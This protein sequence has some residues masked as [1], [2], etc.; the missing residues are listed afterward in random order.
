MTYGPHTLWALRTRCPRE[1]LTASKFEGLWSRFLPVQQASPRTF[2]WDHSRARLEV[3]C[4]NLTSATAFLG[5]ETPDCS[6]EHARRLVY[7]YG[8]H[9]HAAML[10]DGMMREG[11]A[12]G[13]FAIALMAARS[14]TSIGD[15]PT[16]HAIYVLGD[17]L[18]EAG[19][20]EYRRALRDLEQAIRDGWPG[21][22]ARGVQVLE[23]PA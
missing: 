6:P 16:D 3:S 22:S 8:L 18:M 13:Q 14:P 5:V 1:A 23:M 15:A 21:W 10:E 7:G 11:L 20:A 9:L 19:R 4:H 12:V 2:A 17:R